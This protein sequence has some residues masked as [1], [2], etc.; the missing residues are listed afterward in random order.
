MMHPTPGKVVIDRDPPEERTSSGVLVLPDTARENANI[1]TVVAVNRDI[2]WEHG[3]GYAPVCNVGDRVLVGKYSGVEIDYEGHHL[4][5]LAQKEILAILPPRPAPVATL[6]K[7]QS[8][9]HA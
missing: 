6:M 9:V 7:E 3:M 8:G 5:V 1:G 2:Y 4:L